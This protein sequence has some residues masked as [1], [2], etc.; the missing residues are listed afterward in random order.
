MSCDLREQTL[1]AIRDA[2]QGNISKA[3]VTVEV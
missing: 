3:K 1:T 2:A